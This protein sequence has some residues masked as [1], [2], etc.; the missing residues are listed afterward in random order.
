VYFV[1]TPRVGNTDAQRNCVSNIRRGGLS[2]QEAVQTL[3]HLLEESLRRGLSGVELKDLRSLRPTIP[4][5][6]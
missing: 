6:G 5:G 2:P 4:S 3:Q 1:H